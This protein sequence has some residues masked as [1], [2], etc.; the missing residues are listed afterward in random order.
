[1]GCFLTSPILNSMEPNMVK[2]QD[3][4][5]AI[6]LHYSDLCKLHDFYGKAR[7]TGRLEVRYLLKQLKLEQRK[8]LVRVFSAFRQDESDEIFIDYRDFVFSIWNFCTMNEVELCKFAFDMYD[9][10]R[11]YM[12]YYYLFLIFSKAIY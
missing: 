2:W 3:Q 4:F 5:D 6:Q 12:T 9:S 8:F 7:G 1:M 10:S 11:R